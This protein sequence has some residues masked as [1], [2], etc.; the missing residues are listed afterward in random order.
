[1]VL[2]QLLEEGVLFV[3]QKVV[4]SNAAADEDLFHPRELAQLPK[5]GHI[6]GVVGI[7][8]FAG[9]GVEALPPAAGTFG[10]LLFAGRV[11]EIGGGAAHIVDVALEIL[12]LHHELRLFQDGFMAPHLDDPPLVEGQGA[13]GA[14]P[15]AAPVAHQAK[16]H[17]LNGGHAPGLFVAGVVGAAVGKIVNRVHFRRGQG[18]LGR[19]LHHKFFS[20]LLRQPLGGEGVAVA[21][22]NFEGLGV[23]ALIF[24]HFLKG[25]QQDGGEALIQLGGF[26]NRAV[27]VG[28]VLYVHAGVQGIGNLHNALFSHA[29]HQ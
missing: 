27:D 6:V 25:G 29:V 28:D 21:V 24:L 2:H 15:E 19:V 13:E 9:C 11:A 26:E 5:Q 4:K 3:R 23:A 22:L 20:V 17:F 12:V 8:I 1:M 14:G 18:L 16:L 10:Q 7:H